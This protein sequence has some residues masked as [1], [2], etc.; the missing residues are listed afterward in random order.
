MVIT[1]RIGQS[2]GKIPKSDG[3]NSKWQGYGIPSTT[4]AP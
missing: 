3:I 1:V 4:G 2:A